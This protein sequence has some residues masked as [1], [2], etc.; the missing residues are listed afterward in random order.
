MPVLHRAVRNLTLPNYD[1]VT[2]VL[3]HP[4]R[5][6]HEVGYFDPGPL[7]MLIDNSLHNP[8]RSENPTGRHTVFGCAQGEVLYLVGFHTDVF[9]DSHQVS[10]LR[11]GGSMMTTRGVPTEAG[12]ETMHFFAV[13]GD[14]ILT[15][16][17][18]TARKKF[19]KLST[20]QVRHLFRNDQA[21]LRTIS[22]H[23][24]RLIAASKIRRSLSRKRH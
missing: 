4:F 2:T 6:I 12:G 11:D 21:A 18:R 9:R 19:M 20:A 23:H 1:D 16:A 22:P 7:T 3:L 13:V 8:Q 5:P 24:S 17:M 14:D 15:K 10:M